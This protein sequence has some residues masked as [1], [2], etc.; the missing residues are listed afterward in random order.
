[1][2][3]RDGVAG[4]ICLAGSAILLFVTR[5]LPKP[6]LVPIGPGFYPRILLVAT[7]LLSLALIVSDVRGGW[8][9][10]PPAT[11]PPVRYGLV[12]VTFAVF[13]AYVLL[14]PW[15]GY[16]LAT[17]VFVTALQVAISR[18]YSARGWALVLAVAVATSAAT[19]Y[20]FEVYL[21]VLL[22]RGRFTAF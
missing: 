10:R 20:A 4:L 2:L 22:P 19:Y 17:L 5:G 7:A 11:A 14:M 9:G 13:T 21:H 3:S 15:I 1:V 6:A 18:P 16:R 12:V 8:R